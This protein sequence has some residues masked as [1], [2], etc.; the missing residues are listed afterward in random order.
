MTESLSLRYKFGVAMAAGLVLVACAT[1][2]AGL[3]RSSVPIWLV[4]VLLWGAL[5]VAVLVI[6]VSRRRQGSR[7]QVLSNDPVPSAGTRSVILLPFL[8]LLPGIVAVLQS[9]RLQMSFHGFLHSAYTYQIVNGVVPPENP[10][11]PGHPGN[12]YWLF[13]ALIAGLVHSLRVAPPLVAIG[14]NLIALTVSAFLI[15]GILRWLRLWPTSPV[16]RGVTV[17]FVLFGLN[18]VG[19]IN[20][21][22]TDS[23]MTEPDLAHMVHIGG[24]RSAG[25]LGKY[26]NFN[27][28]PLGIVFFLLAVS[29]GLR[30]TKRFEAWALVGFAS[31]IL[32]AL[33]FHVTTGAFTLAT[34]PAALVISML[35]IRH[36]WKVSASR[37]KIALVVG[38]MVAAMVCLGHYVLVTATALNGSTRVDPLNARNASRLILLTAPLIPLFVL[39]VVHAF[40]ERRRDLLMLSLTTVGG[41]ILACGLVL[42][43]GN[44]Y[45]F[46]YLSALP[47]AVVAVAGWR[48][49]RSSERAWVPKFAVFAGALAVALTLGNQVYMGLAY[50]DSPFATNGSIAYEGPDV[51]GAAG[52]Q[53]EAWEWLRENSPREA[54]V[55]L[56]VMSKDDASFLAISQRLPYVLRGAIYT[57]GNPDFEDRISRVRNLYSERTSTDVKR[58]IVADMRRDIGGRPLF[59]AVARADAD[60]VDGDALALERVFTTEQISLYRLGT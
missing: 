46:D 8:A 21:W 48:V 17:L 25:L 59:I 23:G 24:A 36:P 51:V 60:A 32:G 39:G 10:L 53:A 31:G 44:Q 45:K 20:A 34:L 6:L 40:R 35:L 13:H 55:V 19:L 4:D 18:L 56:P 12:D 5:T 38:T 58:G 49:L 1:Y 52:T 22:G 7:S 3:M 57:S 11:L 9:T 26:L 43:G 28:F 41:A 42:P 14:V 33:A 15:A 47:M 2:V 29:S 37:S 54:I 30:L 27:G 50:M 16:A